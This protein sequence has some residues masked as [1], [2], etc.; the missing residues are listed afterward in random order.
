MSSM[1][2]TLPVSL[3][4][5]ALS[6]FCVTDITLI[7]FLPRVNPQVT[8]QFKRIRTGIRA[9]RTLEWPF[10]SMTSAISKM[11]Y[12]NTRLFAIKILFP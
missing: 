1:N 11:G 3:Q 9:V 12:F 4:R 6:K 2:E 10:P 7:G 5:I 8:L